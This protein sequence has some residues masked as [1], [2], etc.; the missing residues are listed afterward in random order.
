MNGVSAVL[1]P[2]V[3]RVPSQAEPELR[4]RAVRVM[5]KITLFHT[6]RRAGC[7]V[8]RSAQRVATQRLVTTQG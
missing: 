5:R 1:S 6:P 3:L 7:R 4:S 8:H 2:G